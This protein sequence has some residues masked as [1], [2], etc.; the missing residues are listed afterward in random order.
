MITKIIFSFASP[1]QVAKAIQNDEP[2]TQNLL[3]FVVDHLNTFYLEMSRHRKMP[4]LLESGLKISH[5]SMKRYMRN[6]AEDIQ[7]GAS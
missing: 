7:A 2:S 1:E 6:L 5:Q 3:V 4:C